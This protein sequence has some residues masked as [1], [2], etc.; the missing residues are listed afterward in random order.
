[1]GFFNY[2]KPGPGIDKNAPK[3]KGV[4]LYLELFFRKFWELI[5]INVLYFIFSIPAFFMYF[6]K[7]FCLKIA[8]FSIFITYFAQ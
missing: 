5:R 4:A 7:I 3:K 8:S 2:S 1:M 6:C